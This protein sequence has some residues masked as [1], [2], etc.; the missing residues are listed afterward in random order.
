MLLDNAPRN[1]LLRL[2]VAVLPKKPL[3][4][5]ILDFAGV[6]QR[7][8]GIETHKLREAI[9]SCYVPISDSGFNGMLVPPPGLV[10]VQGSAVEKSFERR[11]AEFDR[12]LAGGAGNGD[13]TDLA[14][15]IKRIAIARGAK[16][17]GSSHAEPSS[18]VQRHGN[19]G[20]QFVAIDE[21][22]IG[23]AS[24]R[25]RVTHRGVGGR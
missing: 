10:L 12:E 3:R 6:G 13:W 22:K 4:K 17:S 24:C 19:T 20:R 14:G 18:E 5:A 11:R 7:R 9:H 23:R 2:P 21:I 16:C 15:G 1:Q 8:I 25:E